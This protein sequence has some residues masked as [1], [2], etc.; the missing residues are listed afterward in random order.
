MGT[1]GHPYVALI[2]PIGDIHILLL[3][4][5]GFWFQLFVWE[6]WGRDTP[7]P[8]SHD[9]YLWCSLVGE[10]KISRNIIWSTLRIIMKH[11]RIGWPD[12]SRY[13]TRCLILNWYTFNV[14]FGKY[15]NFNKK[16]CCNMLHH[17]A[18]PW[19]FRGRCRPSPWEMKDTWQDSKFN[20]FYEKN[21]GASDRFSPLDRFPRGSTCFLDDNLH[22]SKHVSSL[23]MRPT[24]C[25][26]SP[27]WKYIY[28]YSLMT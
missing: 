5:S 25:G 6:F 3:F 19:I 17:V 4:P 20:K 21:S 24:G 8:T 18:R 12:C 15:S 22:A 13:P 10:W 9:F 2:F 14:T 26:Q 27:I 16:Y 11:K 28:Y 7:S 1:L 23:D